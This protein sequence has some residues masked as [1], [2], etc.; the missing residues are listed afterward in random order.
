MFWFAQQQGY[1]EI[2]GGMEVPIVL[3]LLVAY[4]SFSSKKSKPMSLGWSSFLAG[5]PWPKGS[6]A[7]GMVVH[8]AKPGLSPEQAACGLVF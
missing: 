3:V 1:S 7:T 8:D 4:Y 2:L 5:H 6:A